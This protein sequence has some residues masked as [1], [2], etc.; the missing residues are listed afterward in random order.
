MNPMKLKLLSIVAIAMWLCP[1]GFGSSQ[2]TNT[3]AFATFYENGG[4]AVFLYVGRDGVTLDCFITCTGL[5]Y[6]FCVDETPGCLEGTMMIPDSA[7]KGNVGASYTNG[8]VLTVNATVTSGSPS[9]NSYYCYAWDSDGDCTDAVYITGTVGSVEAT[10]TKYELAANVT[11][12]YG[13]SASGTVQTIEDWFDDQAY[14]NVIG[15]SFG[16]TDSCC[17]DFDETSTTATPTNATA[18]VATANLALKPS[19]IVA[20]T[21]KVPEKVL[22]RLRALERAQ[23]AA[24]AARAK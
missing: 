2:V 14:G 22:R 4:N 15:V 21:G 1:Q 10:F 3:G 11:D 9:G 19:E 7:F 18:N 12:S 6:S 17:L 5:T 23:K 24:I 13:T 20:R 16:V 8:A